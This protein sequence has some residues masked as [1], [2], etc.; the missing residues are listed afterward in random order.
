[1]RCGAA[2]GFSPH[3]AGDAAVGTGQRWRDGAAS[4]RRL[5]DAPPGEVCFGTLA[6]DRICY[7]VGERSDGT[8]KFQVVPEIDTDD[9][10]TCTGNVNLAA[11]IP[12]TR[13]SSR[14]ATS[15]SM[16]AP[17]S[18]CSARVR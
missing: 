7:L 13:A 10:P 1:M 18:T 15:G 3:A 9:V 2:C 16:S 14:P 4:R 12:G 6:Y 11:A 8:K 5:P 17:S